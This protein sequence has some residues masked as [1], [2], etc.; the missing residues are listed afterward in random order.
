VPRLS[1]R[2]IMT[3]G[4][5]LGILLPALVMGSLVLKQR[6]DRELELRIHEPL[7][8]YT[9]LLS[10]AL[11]MPIWNVDKAVAK[12]LMDA[13]MRNPDVVEVVVLDELGNTFVSGDEQMHRQGLVLRQQSDVVM[14]SK[15]IGLVRVGL[16]T[17]RIEHQLWI[18]FTQLG[19][20]LLAQVGISFLLVFLLVERRVVHPLYRL[21]MATVRLARG[22]LD[23]PLD[24]HRHDE[25]GILAQGLDTMRG[26]LGGL[27]A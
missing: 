2:Q 3:L 9:Q 12:Q 7:S 11:A 14:D 4:V 26:A 10:S 19:L 6:Y 20:A 18:D 21:Q 16:S 22:E 24:W 8:Q 5:A 1:L 25:I 17:D 15:R 27:I 23:Q 13:V